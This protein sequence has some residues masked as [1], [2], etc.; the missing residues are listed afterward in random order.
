[1]ATGSDPQGAFKSVHNNKNNKNQNVWMLKKNS[2][3]HVHFG[4]RKELLVQHYAIPQSAAADPIC[5]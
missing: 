2:N 3:G 4:R 1:M 5:C